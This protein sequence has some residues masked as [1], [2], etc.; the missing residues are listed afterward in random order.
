MKRWYMRPAARF[1]AEGRTGWLGIK[2]SPSA[3]SSLLHSTTLSFLS[4]RSA[5]EIMS[6]SPPELLQIPDNVHETLLVFKSLG[7]KPQISPLMVLRRR[8]KMTAMV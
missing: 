6:F 8:L 1:G 3:P 7:I 5:E 2:S 4:K